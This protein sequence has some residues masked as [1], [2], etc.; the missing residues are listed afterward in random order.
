MR[1]AYIRQLI[2]DGRL[3]PHAGLTPDGLNADRY[4]PQDTWVRCRQC[5]AA[6]PHVR[7]LRHDAGCRGAWGTRARAREQAPPR[8]P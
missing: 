6:A 1:N 8:V 2:A 7:D 3:D 4:A 5:D